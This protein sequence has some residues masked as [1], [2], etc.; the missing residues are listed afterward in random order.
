MVFNRVNY[1][2]KRGSLPEI[3]ATDKRAGIAFS[4][5]YA[6]PQGGRGSFL[7]FSVGEAARRA[8]E[9]VSSTF[10][11]GEGACREDEGSSSTFSV[12]EGARRA[13]VSSSSTFSVGEAARRADE[14]LFTLSWNYV[15][16][17]GKYHPPG[18]AKVTTNLI[19]LAASA[20]LAFG[21]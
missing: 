21:T 8:D 14:G 3:N 7:T 12:R 20:G 5:G 15:C 16:A 4:P 1:T 9:G 13:D 10:S 19:R 17:N 2:V 18:C 6:C 11:V